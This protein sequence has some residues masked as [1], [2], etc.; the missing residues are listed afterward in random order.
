V[1][2]GELSECGVEVEEEHEGREIKK[3]RT[4]IRDGGEGEES[5]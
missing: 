4:E 2:A 5:E 1:I 3:R